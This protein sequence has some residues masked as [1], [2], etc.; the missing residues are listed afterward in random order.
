MH[1]KSQYSAGFHLKA[2]I[3]ITQKPGVWHW[4]RL[5]VSDLTSKAAQN[6]FYNKVIKSDMRSS[7]GDLKI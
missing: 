2:H 3:I 7:N 1:P 4:P 6:V 5:T